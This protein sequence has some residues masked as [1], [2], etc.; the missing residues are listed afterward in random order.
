M[1]AITNHHKLDGLKQQKFILSP[2]QRP[3]VQSQ[4]V[5][6]IVPPPKALGRPLV[7]PLLAS[8]GPRHPWACGSITPAFV[9]TFTWPSP[10]GL[11]PSSFLVRTL[12]T[13]FRAQPNP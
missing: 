12:L 10:P 5:V 11:L 2:F 1:A 7:L 4:S 3:E 9:S 8:G 13:G 6:R